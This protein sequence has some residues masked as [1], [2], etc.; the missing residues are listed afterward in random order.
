VSRARAIITAILLAA[1]AVLA[2]SGPATPAAPRIAA[3]T[4][5]PGPHDDGPHPPLLPPAKTSPRPHALRATTVVNAAGTYTYAGPDLHDGITARLPD[6]TYAMYGTMYVCGY[7]W[8]VQATPWCGF[9]VSTAPSLAGPWTAPTR[10]F[11]PNDIDPW[12]GLTWADECGGNGQGCFN[13]RMIQRS[14][15]G[16]N[17]GT[18]ILW[19]NSPVDYSRNHAN[20]YNAMGCN[21]PLGPCGPSAGAPHGSYSKPSLSVC[22]GNGD[23]G[24]IQSGT[25]GQAPAIVCTMPGAAALNIEQINQWGVGGTGTGVHNVAGL[26]SIEGPGGWYDPATGTYVLTY[27]DPGCGYCAGT[28]TGYATSTSL[29]GGWTAPVNVGF[30]QPTSG[31]RTIAANSCGGQPRTVSVIDGQP[32]QGIDLWEGTRNETLAGTVLAPLTYGPTAGFAGDGHRWIPPVS[33][34]C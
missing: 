7:Q 5:H 25:Q 14:G 31:R 3:A 32:Y 6:G 30:G 19:F 8:Y 22:G 18:W 11:S 12:S 2:A 20:A 24:I 1:T 21:G 27:S 34:P 10:L 9:G 29:Y 33:Y 4:V 17:D 13:P 16:S 23:F 28:A 15:W 26:T